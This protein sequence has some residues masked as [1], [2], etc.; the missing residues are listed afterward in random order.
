M[1]DD[2]R[3]KDWEQLSMS[4]KVEIDVDFLRRRLDMEEWREREKQWL[5]WERPGKQEQHYREYQERM[6]KLRLVEW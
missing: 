4:S 2:K 6:A 3:Q 5:Q 1:E